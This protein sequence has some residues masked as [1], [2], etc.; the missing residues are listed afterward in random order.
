MERLLAQA[1]ERV[2]AVVHANA[3]A[4]AVFLAGFRG[5]TQ[6]QIAYGQRASALA[7]A[8]EDGDKPAL[9]WALAAQT[10]GAQAAGDI[11][12]QFDIGKRVILL[13]Q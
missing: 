4:Y 12:T 10:Y 8:L 3:L 11:Q 6:A 13:N 9:R 2:P 5:N 7:E 1:D